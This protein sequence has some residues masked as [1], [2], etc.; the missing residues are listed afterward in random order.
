MTKHFKAAF[1]LV[2]VVCFLFS[3]FNN[4]EAVRNKTIITI[5]HAVDWDQYLFTAIE[6]FNKNNPDIE[7]KVDQTF[8]SDDSFQKSADY[9]TKLTTE[10][11]AGKAPDIIDVTYLPYL[12]FT[13]RGILANLIQLIDKDQTFNLND[14]Y[15]NILKSSTKYNSLYVIPV[16]FTLP[17]FAAD[18]DLLTSEGIEFKPDHTWREFI[19]N[20][21]K[22]KKDLNGDGNPDRYP[23][24]KI[25]IPLQI[26][27]MMDF[28]DWKAKKAN[29]LSKDFEELLQLSREAIKKELEN[30]NIDQSQKH[31]AIKNGTVVFWDNYVIQNYSDFD[32]A[33][34]G[35]QKD[36][37]CFITYP[38][39]KG[40][41][42]V[43]DYNNLYAINAHSKHPDKAWRFIKFVISDQ[44]QNNS[45]LY[46]FPINKK[47]NKNMLDTYIAQCAKGNIKSLNSFG[48]EW[49][50]KP[51][52][53]EDIKQIDELISK[54]N[55]GNYYDL[56]L[57]KIIYSEIKK[58]LDGQ[59]T[60]SETARIIQSK[61]E[62]YLR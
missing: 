36:N 30:S 12:R 27:N 13:S 38:S 28:I 26:I 35:I 40:G 9:E 58:C 37:I 49:I 19:N 57:K 15:Q 21:L 54:A 53:K 25:N 56:K 1:M 8:K 11:L 46:G 55:Q 6:I 7:V 39:L 24:A 47:A 43:F 41:G 5:S 14:Y 10:I 61:V 45:N 51:P 17:V 44:M 4:V 3:M 32:N 20:C 60:V 31:E 33:R 16:S 52:T 48:Q 62:V 22:L 50:A 34:V 23:F 59:L 2:L 29:F 42:M 18:K